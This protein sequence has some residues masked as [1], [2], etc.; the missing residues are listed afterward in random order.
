MEAARKSLVAARDMEAGHIIEQED[1]NIKRPGNGISPLFI[2][3]IK[4]KKLIKAVKEDELFTFGH[5]DK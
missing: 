4:G 1:I 2:N 3:D 5:F